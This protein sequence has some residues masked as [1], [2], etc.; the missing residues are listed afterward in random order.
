MGAVSVD[1]NKGKLKFDWSPFTKPRVMANIPLGYKIEKVDENGVHYYTP[2]EAEIPFV[3]QALEFVNG[4][5]S[6]RDAAK[7]LSNQFNRSVSHM[8]VSNTW[9]KRV[10]NASYTVRAKKLAASKHN[11]KNKTPEEKE[12]ENLNRRRG[13][14]KRSLTSIINKENRL[15]GKPEITREELD[16]QLEQQ[17][18]GKKPQGSSSESKQTEEVQSNPSFSEDTVEP[19]IE[20]GETIEVG[21]GTEGVKDSETVGPRVI[22]R[23]NPGPQTEFL[24]SPELEVLYGGAAGGGKSYALI[25]DPMRY[26]DNPNF[27]GVLIRRTNDEL[28]ELKYKAKELYFQLYL[29]KSGKTRVRYSE[30]DSTFVFPSGAKLWLTYLDSREDLLRFQGQ[31]FTWVGMDELTQYPTSEFW[32]YLRSRLRTTDPRLKNSLSMRGTTNPGGPGHGWVKRMFVDPSIPNK[33]FPAQNIDTGETL[34]YNGKDESRKGKPLFYRKFIPA[35]LYDNPYL[36]EDGNYEASLMSLPENLRRQLLEGDWTIAEG[37]AF[38]EF[39]LSTH[40]VEPFEIPHSWRKFR[41]CDYG[42]SSFSACYWMA[43]DPAFEQLVVYRELY[44]TKTTGRELARQIL[45]IEQENNENIDYGILDAAVWHKTGQTGP[46]I[47]EEMIAEGCRW[48][49]ADNKHKNSRSNGKNRLHELLKVDEDTGK[50]GIIIFNTCRQIIAD[51]QVI[52]T[53]PDGD[54]DIDKRYSSDHSYDALRYGIMSRPRSKSFFELNNISKSQ[55]R[56]ANSVFG[57]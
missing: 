13:A 20:L 9:K 1:L 7:W 24:A 5:G 11:S 43:V 3:E 46:S 42:Y 17:R 33:P 25:A 37:A 35:S 32:D 30:K 2:N 53:S 8:T 31:A 57:Y 29:D 22:F 39:R 54:D 45:Q 38:P 10:T 40:V 27:N 21:A 34:I 23:P 15:L 28:R 49:P 50:P 56:P 52:P 19:S 41:S 44:V 18:N 14:L 55:Y 51:L 16:R 6:L 12:L 26:F 47:A 36:S 48:R 4:G